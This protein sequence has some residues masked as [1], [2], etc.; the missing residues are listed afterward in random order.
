MQ[1]E[2]AAGR[3]WAVVW[4]VPALATRLTVH[5]VVEPVATVTVPD[6]TPVYWGETVTSKATESSLP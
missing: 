3:A 2:A 6:G 4:Q 5:R 1:G